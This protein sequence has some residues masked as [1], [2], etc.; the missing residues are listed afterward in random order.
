MA[1]NDPVRGRLYEIANELEGLQV[2]WYAW[3]QSHSVET[4]CQNYGLKPA[5]A[6]W[7]EAF[8]FTRVGEVPQGEKHPPSVPGLL[9]AQ[10]ARQIYGDGSFGGKYQATDEIM[11]EVFD[12]AVIDIIHLL[13]F[14]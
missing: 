7:L 5:H 6:N 2:K 1:G 3:W 14:E 10:E 12:G 13:K 11:Q 8:P 9:G 4:I